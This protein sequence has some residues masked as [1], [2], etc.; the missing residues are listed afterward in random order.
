MADLAGS[1]I[2]TED[3][4]DSCTLRYAIEDILGMPT[5]E[6]FLNLMHDPS[7]YD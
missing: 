2:I 5:C 3:E 6:T 4:L 1:N 7:V